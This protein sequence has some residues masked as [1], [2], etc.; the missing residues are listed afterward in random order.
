MAATAPWDQAMPQRCELRAGSWADGDGMPSA[1]SASALLL[2]D[3]ELAG[4]RGY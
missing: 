4:C 1:V 2:A 3:S